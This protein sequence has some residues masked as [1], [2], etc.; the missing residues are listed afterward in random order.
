MTQD[1]A[2]K[3]LFTGQNVFLTGAAG[4]GKTYILNQYISYLKENN[5]PVAITAPTGIAATHMDGRT[6]HSWSGI[7]MRKYL[8]KK[9]LD[10]LFYNTFTHDRINGAR[11][12]IIDEISMLDARI[13]ALLDQV[14]KYVRNK[15]QFF[16]G[17]QVVFCGDFFQLPPVG[18]KGEPPP[19]YAFQSPLWSAANFRVCYLEEQHR[20]EDPIFLDMLNSIRHSKVTQNTI[21]V[22]KTRLNK[23][24][25]GLRKVTKLYS[26]RDDVDSINDRELDI[27][28]SQPYF[29]KMLSGGDAE[30]VA[31]LIDS[32]LAPKTLE[33]KEGA[34]VMFVRN[35]SGEGY[36]NGTLGV[37]VGFE[38]EGP[39]YP[40][41]E[42]KEGNRITAR[43]VRWNVENEEGEVLAYI[44][45]V[46][47]RLA[48]AI[49]IHKSQGMTL[50]GAEI[51]L[52]KAWG[53]GMGYVALSRVRTLEGIK[54]IG[55]NRTALQVSP[56]VR[57]FD[58]ILREQSEDTKQLMLEDDK[59]LISKLQSDFLI[60]GR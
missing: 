54:L 4:T 52:S 7:A 45:Q 3:I 59:T 13:F 19:Q 39:K 30:L 53:H 34:L 20:H 55:I 1:E 8:T 47:L 42:T 32:C 6:V 11:V 2:L 37:V 49:T 60:R 10:K 48:W 27:I 38:E 9:D 28:Q 21:D 14:C 35:N 33:L 56:I 36:V 29:Y 17:L 25:E 43:S 16:G 22:L 44:D 15:S 24:I 23:P 26:H 51:N 5:I 50:D 31:S 18:D 58:A 40:I 46:P 57:E 41:I 12:L